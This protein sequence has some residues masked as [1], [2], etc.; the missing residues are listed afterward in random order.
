MTKPRMFYHVTPESNL[1]SIF[2]KGLMPTIGERSAQ[3][4]SMP[5]VF[6]FNSLEDCE[7]ALANWL[8]EEFEDIYERLAVLE[9]TLP[10][11][12]PLITTVEWESASGTVISP[13]QIQIHHYE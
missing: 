2:E 8:G 9:V 6:L 4:E 11:S 7:T 12:F 1:E 13:N 10:D 3:C 5:L